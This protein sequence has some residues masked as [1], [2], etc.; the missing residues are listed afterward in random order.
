MLSFFII[1]ELPFDFHTVLQKMCDCVDLLFL[2]KDAR[3][4]AREKLKSLQRRC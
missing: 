4:F 1:N 3:A 2:R